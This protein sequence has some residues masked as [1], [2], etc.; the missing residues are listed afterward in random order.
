MVLKRRASGPEKMRK[1]RER[2]HSE[3]RSIRLRTT[4]DYGKGGTRRHTPKQP[5][6]RYEMLRLGRPKAKR[7]KRIGPELNGKAIDEKHVDAEDDGTIV[8]GCEILTV[9]FDAD[10]NDDTDWTSM[11]ARST[12]MPCS[13]ASRRV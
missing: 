3:R 11:V 4:R 10:E 12:A 1:N 13:S 5:T 9:G 8:D 2:Q 6:R 7:T